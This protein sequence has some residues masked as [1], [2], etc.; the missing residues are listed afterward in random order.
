VLQAF[1]D[2]SAEEDGV[3][4]L[5]GYIARAE[6]WAKFSDIWERM[7]PRFGTP[8]DDGRYHFKMK[9]MAARPDGIAKAE[10]FFRVIEEHVLG[11]V[12]AR[13]D[14]TELKNAIARIHV[15]GAIIEDW[16]SHTN[17]WYIAFRYLMD[18][19]HLERAKMKEVFQDEKID[20]YF[21]NGV[22]KKTI[23][24]IW[25]NYVNSRKDE[26]KKY[27]GSLP[28]FE[29]DTE[30]LPLQAADFWVWWVRKWH[31]EGTPEKIEKCDFGAFHPRRLRK[32]LRFA[33]DVREDDLVKNL[34][35]M[36]RAAVGPDRPIL[37]LKTGQPL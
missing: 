35:Q 14:Q 10:P 36:V 9:E 21:D 1:I 33:A 19:F 25:D 17:P 29:D 23:Y 24:A 28:R 18:R 13:I 31:N 6:D 20:F 26:I 12:S 7:L 11:W 3:F 16:E 22:D 32:T 2:E 15:P 8:R 37:D 5:G 27:Y 34:S 30:H 4:V